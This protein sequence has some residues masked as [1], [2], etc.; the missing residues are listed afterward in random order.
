[1]RTR[2]IMGDIRKFLK[3]YQPHINNK[4]KRKECVDCLLAIIPHYCGNHDFCLDC[5]FRIIQLENPT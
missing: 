3:K 5:N 2:S 4:E 1:M